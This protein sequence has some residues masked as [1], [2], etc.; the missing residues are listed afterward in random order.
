VQLIQWGERLVNKAQ[1]SLEYLSVIGISLLMIIPLLL[2]FAHQSVSYQDDV[3]IAHLETVAGEL[4]KASEEVFYLG[5]P[6]QK[7]LRLYFP[8]RLESIVIEEQAIVFTLHYSGSTITY[9][10][11]SN[12]PLNL[13]G[14]IDS[15]GGLHIITVTALPTGV[16][17]QESS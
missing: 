11:T 15:R 8:D 12:L 7:Q 2:L 10:V 3:N 1:V 6:T 14:T 9:P 17:L 13:H 16:H 5:P 4:M